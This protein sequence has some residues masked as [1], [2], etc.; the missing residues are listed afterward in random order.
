MPITTLSTSEKE[1]I[2]FCNHLI[3]RVEDIM[4][5][6]KNLHPE[7]FDLKSSNKEFVANSMSLIRALL[8]KEYFL[9]ISSLLLKD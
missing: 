7:G 3:N 2:N 9:F 8:V 1:K 4:K 6:I 5:K